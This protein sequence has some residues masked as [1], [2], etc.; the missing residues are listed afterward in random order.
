MSQ[1]SSSSGLSSGSQAEKIVIV[2]AGLVGSVL[3]IYLARRGFAVEVYERRCDFRR[4]D[5]DASRSSINL[6]LSTR[7]LRALDQVGVGDAVRKLTVPTYGR[8]IHG[9]DNDLT[10]QAYGNNGE[11]TYAILRNDLNRV[12]IDSAIKLGVNFY[13]D[14]KCLDIDLASG[15]LR[16]EDCRTGALHHVTAT[17]IFG[18]DGLHSTVRL[19]LQR[20]RHFNYSQTYLDHGYKE[21]N[22]PANALAEWAAMKTAVH[23]WPRGG[24]MLLGLPNVDGSFVCSLHLPLEGSPSFASIQDGSDLLAF[25]E[26]S[27]PDVMGQIPDAVE[28]FFSHST[29]YFAEIRCFPWC[30]EDRVAL[31]G[32]AAHAI[33]PFYAQG[34][35]AGFEDCQ[36]FDQCLEEYGLNW[37]QVF[38]GFQ[39]RRK[40]DADAVSDLS[41]SHFYE[42]RDLVGKPSFQLRK[43][44]ERKLNEIYPNEF[45]PLYSMVSFE[46]IPY[47]EALRRDRRQR[48]IVDRVLAI[49]N[50]EQMSV[51]DLE[52]YLSGTDLFSAIHEDAAESNEERGQ[53]VDQVEREAA[54]V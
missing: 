47:S 43:L 11:A 2:G 14:E 13:F 8:A 42:L 1:K 38:D 31:I 44:V 21:L 37:H 32:D 6:S 41:R 29:N 26:S 23:L 54:T 17:R 49:P 40:P 46:C 39:R 50:V 52:D 35:N 9:T 45:I 28:S 48:A 27:F 30:F 7:G 51:G 22:V 34:V 10:Y 25:L 20:T 4:G 19:R 3:A 33:F 18:A 36:I 5:P 24:Y 12:L 16:F 15:T 53:H